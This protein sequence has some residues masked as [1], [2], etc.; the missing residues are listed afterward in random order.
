MS[1]SVRPLTTA[2]VTYPAPDGVSDEAL[3]MLV[4]PLMLNS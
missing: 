4:M 1:S 2:D 3:L